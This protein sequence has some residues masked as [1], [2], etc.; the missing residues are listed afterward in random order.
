[1]ILVDASGQNRMQ[2]N[3]QKQ[4]SQMRQTLQIGSLNHGM[5]ML[6]IVAGQ[7]QLTE[8]VWKQ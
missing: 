2:V 3:A 4:T 8:K 5:Y 1:M 7:T 6:R